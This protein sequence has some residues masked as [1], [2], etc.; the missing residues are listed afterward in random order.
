MHTGVELY[1][2]QNGL[3]WEVQGGDE[4]REISLTK[5]T[6]AFLIFSPC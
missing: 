1:V 6:P 5:M 3:S 2:V 4:G